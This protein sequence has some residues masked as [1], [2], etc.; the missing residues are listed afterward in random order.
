MVIRGWGLVG[1]GLL[2]AL[3]ATPAAASSWDLDLSLRTRHEQVRDSGAADAEAATSRLRV[4][5]N[6][7]WLAGRL[8]LDA[9]LDQVVAIGSVDYSTG[10]TDRGTAI[11]AD[12]EGF[13]LNGL[14]LS[15]RLPADTRATV[16][17]QA[18]GFDNS[19][20]VGT[21]Q[22]RQNSQS[23]DAVA[24]ENRY[25]EDLKLTY[26]Y[27]DKVNRIFGDDADREF[28]EDD[29][30]FGSGQTRPGPQLGRHDH[31]THL[32]HAAWDGWQ[33]GRLSAYAYLLDVSDFERYSVDTYGARFAGKHKPGAL[34]YLYSLE[35]AYQESAGA[36]PADY[37]AD[38]YQLSAG[39]SHKR[40][41]LRVAYEVL[42]GS[43]SGAFVTPLGT[44]HQFQGWTDKFVVLTPDIGVR[45]LSMELAWRHR[46]FRARTIYHRFRSD[47][48]SE[49]IGDEW[50]VEVQQRLLDDLLRLNVTYAR[51]SADIDRNIGPGGFQND[52]SKLFVTLW[53][54]IATKRD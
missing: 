9:E 34:A 35:Y 23:F 31:D 20:F 30:R 3:L 18:L 15:L 40:K 13:D 37:S 17:R 54:N 12:P 28:D 7:G 5:I 36:N 19:R 51:Y 45:D 46:G 41:L 14:S 2:A 1:R 25:L 24:L 32:L 38:Y 21:L 42:G 29:R 26:A 8:R 4:G 16:G 53:V 43:D 44:L 47:R 11:I 49:D 48:G 52:T 39:V 50:A 22:F 33:A 6:S 27:V 10:E